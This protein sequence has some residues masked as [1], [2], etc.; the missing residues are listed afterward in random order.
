MGSAK[1]QAKADKKASKAR[2]KAEKKAGNAAAVAPI[3]AG[4]GDGK[5]SPAERSAAAAEKQV[6][7]QRFRVLFALLMFVVA[8]VGLL[9][10]VKPWQYLPG[11]AQP[12]TAPAATTPEEP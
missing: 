12:Q 1:D 10:T 5:P 9:W 11:S 3:A 8:V 6:A 7:L 2:L 4:G